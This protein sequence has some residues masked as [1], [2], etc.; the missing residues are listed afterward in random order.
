[1]S[2]WGTRRTR[3]TGAPTSLWSV[4]ALVVVWLAAATAG[5]VEPRIESPLPIRLAADTDQIRI[6]LPDA[7]VGLYSFYL[8]G[9][10][11][12]AGRER[13]EQVWKP[14]PVEFEAYNGAGHRVSW[15]RRLLKQALQSRRM[16]GFHLHV[17]EAGDHVVTLRLLPGAQEAAIIERIEFVDQLADLP[18]TAIKTRQ[19]LDETPFVRLPDPEL[20]EARAARDR[21]I[22][23]A[24]PPLNVHLQVHGQVAAFRTPPAAAGVPDWQFDAWRELTHASYQIRNLFTPLAIVNTVTGERLE[25]EQVLAGAPLPDARWRDDGTG[26][27]F[28]RADYPELPHDVY[29]SPWA[30][31]MGRRVQLCLGLLGSWDHRGASLISRFVQTADA[32]IAHDAALMLVRMAYDWPALEMNLHEHRLCTHAPDFEYNTD[33][34]Q[35]GR[36]NGK[37]FYSGWS[38]STATDLMKTYDALFPYIQDNQLFA[39]AVNAFIPWV[40]RPQDV[41]RLL[42]QRLVFA[43]VRDYRR[44][45]IRGGEV[46]DVAGEV[47]GPHEQTTEFYDLTK[48]H[49]NIYPF[50]GTFQELYGTA[51]TRLGH[52]HIGSTGYATGHAQTILRKA[53]AIRHARENG[54]DLKM[55]LSDVERHPKVRGAADF[56]IDQFI[57][58]GFWL[59]VGNASGGSGVGWR[60]GAKRLQTMRRASEAAVALWGDPRHAWLLHNVHGNADPDIA[61]LAENGRDPVLHN[62]S[63]ILPGWAGILEKNVAATDPRE[64]TA[65]FMVVGLG[66]GHSHHDFL[67]LNLIAMGLPLA[68]D[69]AVRDEGGHWS[70]P[71]GGWS[72]LHNHA[73]AHD[74]DDPRQAGDQ[75]GE[76]WLRAFAPPLMRGRYVDNRGDVRLD[77]DV[78]LM[79]VGDSQTYYAVDIQ[80]LTGGTTHTWCFHGVQSAELELNVP[81]RP[82]TVRWT[83]RLLAGTQRAGRAADTLH[84]VWTATREAREIPHD[85]RGGGVIRTKALEPAVLGTLYDPELPP[86]QVRATLLGHAGAT[87]LAGNPFSQP[88]D[89][90][91]PFLWVQHPAGAEPSV[92]PAIYEWHRGDTPVVANARLIEKNPLVLEVTTTAGQVDTYRL[93]G[94]AFS[95]VSTDADGVRWAQLVQ[96]T[97]LDMPGLQLQTVA[98]N[99]TTTIVDIDY[100]RRRLRTSAPLPANPSAV[101]GNDGRQSNLELTGEGVEFT[102]KHDLLAHEGRVTAIQI[103]D[104]DTIRLETNP[105]LFHAGAGNRK[106]EGFTITNEDRSWHFRGGAVVRRPNDAALTAEVFADANGDG[107]VHAKTY[108]IGIGDTVTVPA[109]IIVRRTADGC[110]LRTNVPVSGQFDGKPFVLAP[111]LDWQAVR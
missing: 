72:F 81:M 16:Q 89:Y 73:I 22:W 96:G 20:T 40:R 97:A 45:L 13:L 28:S 8:H 33:W 109:S 101:V 59:T 74:T 62:A 49:A 63:R 51:L 87:V 105:R 19:N 52:Y 57:A 79:Q 94:E 12:A 82:E 95:A 48:Q 84:A 67:D 6:V 65:A 35:P 21:L 75:T 69:L 9:R 104:G 27:F 43:S 77:R 68:V 37:Y 78:M 36:R 46:E 108:E 23:D 60:E 41:I 15:G 99:H 110:E 26:L 61:R 64:K 56:L 102:W 3:F 5:A 76:P 30:N 54:L 31:L 83:D 32:E 2:E 25:H 42:D 90:A 80:T 4:P 92:Y 85:Y 58:G 34:S 71:G 55:D 100:Q 17:N 18:A 91:F 47:L 111:A 10:I 24:L 98:A 88:Y 1:M 29:V 39:D 38:G 86:V 14:C 66:Q 7:P 106:P 93:D 53:L 107:F 103:G 50:Q 11:D 70:R 44:N